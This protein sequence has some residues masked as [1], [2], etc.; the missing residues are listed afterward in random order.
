MVKVERHDFGYKALRVVNDEGTAMRLPTK[1]ASVAFR[2]ELVKDSLELERETGLEASGTIDAVDVAVVGNV[3]IATTALTG[4]IVAIFQILHL[5]QHHGGLFVV[6]VDCCSCWPPIDSTSTAS[7]QQTRRW[8]GHCSFLGLM[9][10]SCIVVQVMVLV[11]RLFM[12]PLVH[13]EVLVT[14]SVLSNQILDGHRRTSGKAREVG[15]FI[16][17]P[18]SADAIPVDLLTLHA[19][20]QKLHA[21]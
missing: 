5:V 12:D 11:V 18:C 17:I 7:Y 8:S 21:S 15:L 16:W 2:F 9:V 10:V 13:L 4:H 3:K 20:A 1:N 6:I 14:W 19:T